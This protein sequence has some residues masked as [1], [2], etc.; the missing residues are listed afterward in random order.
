MRVMTFNVRYDTGEDGAHDWHHRR[1]DVFDVIRAH[2]PDLIS[3][4]EPDAS[5]WADISAHLAGYAP[6][7]LFDDGSENLEARGGFFRRSRFD[8]ASQGIFW[9]SDT[10][11]IPHSVTWENDWEPRACGWIRLRDRVMDRELVFA[12][13]HFDTNAGAWRL[14]AETL[15]RELDTIA[16]ATPLIVAGDFNC[17]AGSDAHSYLIVQGGFRDVWYESGHSDAGVLTFHGFTGRRHLSTRENERIDWI[18]VRGELT[19]TEA[20]IDDTS[21]SGKLASDHYPVTAL[22]DWTDRSG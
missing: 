19:C 1:A 16:A 4:Q 21:R 13:T 15:R 22:V 3:L 17:P 5:Q 18:L 14:S 10:P 8:A 7:G 12:S 6:F 20:Q 2:D 11:A 9:L